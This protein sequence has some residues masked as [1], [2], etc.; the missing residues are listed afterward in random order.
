[1]GT[2]AYM[3]PEQARDAAHV[4]QRADVYSLGCTLYD[5]LTGRPPFSGRTAYEVITKHSTEPLVP[6]DRV[7]RH[8]PPTLSAIVVR[9]TAKRPGDRFQTMGEVVEALETFLG[10]DSGKAF[11]PQE[12]A[13]QELEQHVAAFNGATWA[14]ARA[15]IVRG[16]F[17]V[18]GLAA[19]LC[20]AADRPAAGGGGRG[21]VRGGDALF[22]Q[23]IVGV[24][25]GTALFK[26]L[27]PV[28]VRHEPRRRA[29]GS[30]A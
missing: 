16:F 6:P 11:S 5:L 15:W 27:P 19:L 26:Q 28:P 7:A 10:V 9:M 25:G 1:M 24:T 20:A 17:A 29:C 22:Y 14:A 18:C 2:P 30:P 21:G 13:V 23:L 4:D 3:P 12:Q 8:V